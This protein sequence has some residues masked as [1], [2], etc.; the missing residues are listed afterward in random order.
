MNSIPLLDVRDGGPVAHTR[1]R[2]EAAA[3]LREFCLAPV[4]R[5]S[6]HVFLSSIDRIAAHWLRS[7]A[8]PYGED[9][10][11]IAEILGFPGALTLNMSYLF[12][13]TTSAG[14]GPEGAPMLRRSLDWPFG[15]LGLC[16]EIAWQSGAAGQF[17]NVTWPGAAGVLTAMAPGRFCAVINQ[18]PMRRRTRGLIG[19]P[20]DAVINLANAL[21]EDGWPPDHLLRYA[22]ETCADYEAAIELLA[23]EPLARPALFTVTGVNPGEVALIERTERESLVLRGPVVVANDWQEPRFGWQGRMGYEN[24]EERRA[25]IRGVPPGGPVFQWVVP[26]VLNPTTRLVVEM[27][28]AGSGALCARGYET[29]SWRSLPTPATK[30]FNLADAP[31]ALAA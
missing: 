23:R 24:N 2:L 4:P 6:R 14:A 31:P 15:G 22:F 21:R 27:S 30:D 17:Y 20:Y 12:A 29:I 1:A 10:E 26:P 5:W 18:A 19:L 25:S 7:S 13:C 9:L 28:A 8:S 16:V 3:E 11:D